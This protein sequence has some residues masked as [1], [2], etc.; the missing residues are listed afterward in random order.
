MRIPHNS[1]SR[2]RVYKGKAFFYPCPVSHSADW[3]AYFG[4]RANNDRVIITRRDNV[5]HLG[6]QVAFM[7]WYH[8]AGEWG[9]LDTL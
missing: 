3:L 6:L 5:N 4:E 7:T 1:V 9:Q 8:D 2:D